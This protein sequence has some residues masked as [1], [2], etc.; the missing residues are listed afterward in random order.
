MKSLIQ[1]VVITAAL[2]VPIA[3]FAQPKSPKSRAEVRAELIE[4][5]QAGYNPGAAND[6]TYP[7]EIQA[8]TARLAQKPA[9]LAAAKPP[10]ADANDTG[11]VRVG[12]SESGAG[13]SDASNNGTKAIYFGN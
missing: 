4:L 3:S 5:E 12:A 2:V 11:G 9:A 1:A 13:R 6:A 8:A 7:A 10:F